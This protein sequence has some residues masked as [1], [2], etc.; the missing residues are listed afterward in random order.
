MELVLC[1]EQE[2]EVVGWL[3]LDPGPD[4]GVIVSA[5]I[6]ERRFLILRVLLVMA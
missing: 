3:D 2:L 5:L 4:L 6:V 1:E